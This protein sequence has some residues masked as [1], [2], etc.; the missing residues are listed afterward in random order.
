M[1]DVYGFRLA[2]KNRPKRYF[3]TFFGNRLTGDVKNGSVYGLVAAR[4]SRRFRY[5]FPRN[6]R[7]ELPLLMFYDLGQLRG[8]FLQAI[9]HKAGHYL[10][11]TLE[12]NET[13]SK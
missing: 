7:V 3:A 11:R 9:A 13:L 2:L 1:V 5:D 10:N 4:T 12:R 8:F 6:L